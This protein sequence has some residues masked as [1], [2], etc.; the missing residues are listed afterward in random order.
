MAGN[1]TSWVLLLRPMDLWRKKGVERT[2]ALLVSRGKNIVAE[3]SQVAGPFTE[4]KRNKERKRRSD[5]TQGL[6]SLAQV[7]FLVDPGLEVL[8]RKNL[9]GDPAKKAANSSKLLGRVELV[10]AAITTLARVHN[11]NEIHKALI[12]HLTNRRSNHGEPESPD[13]TVPANSFSQEPFPLQVSH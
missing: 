11:D 12:S 6:D 2:K 9:H 13:A 8:A 10:N 3:K 7:I 5:I 1:L 4:R